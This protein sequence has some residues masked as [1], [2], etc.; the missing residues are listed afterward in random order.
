MI[1]DFKTTHVIKGALPDI[2]KKKDKLTCE[3]SPS[4]KPSIKKQTFKQRK[5]AAIG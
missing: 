5:R 3:T 1:F 2:K 4:E